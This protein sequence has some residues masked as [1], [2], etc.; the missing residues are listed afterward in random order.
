M[1]ALQASLDAERRI[2]ADWQQQLENAK[3]EAE[4]A[5]RK[6]KSLMLQH[7][8]SLALCA[9]RTGDDAVA[10]WRRAMTRRVGVWR[11]QFSGLRDD[12][13]VIKSAVG[14]TFSQVSRD[15][16]TF[17]KHVLAEAAKRPPM[18]GKGHGQGGRITGHVGGARGGGY[19][20]PQSAPRLLHSIAPSSNRTPPPPTGGPPMGGGNTYG[21][22]NVAA[23]AHTTSYTGVAS[24]SGG[25]ASSAVSAVSPLEV[26]VH[27]CVVGLNAS[28]NSDSAVAVRPEGGDDGGAS[29]VVTGGGGAD[30]GQH[31]VVFPLDRVFSDHHRAIDVDPTTVCDRG[32]LD[33]AVEV[34]LAGG[35]ATIV[36][37]AGG[38]GRHDVDILH[39]RSGGGGMVNA[40]SSSTSSDGEDGIMVA[41]VRRLFD[42]A[43]A[44][45]NAS[46]EVMI[47]VT[48]AEIA[49]DT[50]NDAL[51]PPGNKPMP[52]SNVQP[53]ASPPLQ[54]MRLDDVGRLHIS[55]AM[56]VHLKT[57]FDFERVRSIIHTRRQARRASAD[58]PLAAHFLLSVHYEERSVGAGGVAGAGAG[59]GAGDGEDRP[60]K[61]R[62][63][64][65]ELDGSVGVAGGVGGGVA[66]VGGG[67]LVGSVD[68]SRPADCDLS[69]LTE[70]IQ[71]AC[72]TLGYYFSTRVQVVAVIP[73][74]FNMRSCV[75][76]SLVV[77]PSLTCCPPLPPH[78][79]PLLLRL[80]FHL[81]LPIPSPPG[82]C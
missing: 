5:K 14:A 68:P 59:G 60:L 77:I 8:E 13:E 76:V 62:L 1:V 65:L 41:L 78:P 10:A 33:A 51:R 23:T 31:E 63:S 16:A 28:S 70:M 64:F 4:A 7:D 38:A 69:M 43:N 67:G 32:N 53:G 2:N 46:S 42:A 35:V 72:S 9:L 3:A 50:M 75:E 24:L 56:A 74:D 39:G 80:P 54:I 29:V 18:A 37:C 47:T 25:A 61:G 57:V 55:N 30:G 15:L 79:F 52:G 12:V 73:I 40:V 45:T 82:C 36:T 34:A 20:M 6:V 71:G 58:N 21:T 44:T 22:I 11:G 26:L 66:G 17:C 19:T 48:A 49:G 81:L 27:G